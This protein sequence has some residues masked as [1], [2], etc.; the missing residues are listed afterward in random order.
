MQQF[1]K[2]Q[3]QILLH[4]RDEK[5]HFDYP[6]GMTENQYYVLCVELRGTNNSILRVISTNDGIISE[7]FPEGLGLLDNFIKEQ[8]EKETKII[9]LNDAQKK[10]LLYMGNKLVYSPLVEDLDEDFNELLLDMK[11]MGIVNISCNLEDS[12][13]FTRKGR[14]LYKLVQIEENNLTELDWIIL[15]EL[16]K[17]EEKVENI[18]A[19]C[20]QLHAYKNIE[21]LQSSIK[22]KSLG[23]I[24]FFYDDNDMYKSHWHGISNEGRLIVRKRNEEE[25]NRD[26]A[27]IFSRQDKHG[28]LVEK[29]ITARDICDTIRKQK[30]INKLQKTEWVKFLSEITGLAES[31]FN[32]FI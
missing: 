8:Q 29:K 24:D 30:L 12:D 18:R 19:V 32:N 17:H 4:I 23:Y 21:I 28:Q 26:S 6:Y 13:V 20:P 1:T 11:Y 16:V 2:Q 10:F 31:S 15:D 27:V 3:F 14:K 25:M 22:L 7:I 5:R 9:E